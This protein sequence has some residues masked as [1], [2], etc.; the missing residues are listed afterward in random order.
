MYKGSYVAIVTPFKN[1][2]IDEAGLRK[3]L[4]F[5]IDNGSDGIVACATTG[6]S[7]SLS[8]EEYERII[9]ICLEEADSKVPVIAGAGTNSTTKTIK[10][11]QKAQKLG[12]NGLLIVTPYYN[13]PTQQG[14]YQHYKTVSNETDLPIIIYNVPGR[15]GV[16][17]LPQTVA[18]LAKDCKNIVAIK[19][20]SGNLDQVSELVNLLGDG[21]DILSG[22]DSLTLPMLS[23][24]AKGVISVIANI[25]PR[26]VSDMCHFFINGKFEEAKKLH[27]KM[28]PVVKALFIETNP[29]PVKKAME[30]MGLP[31]GNPRLPLV[32][33]SEENTAVLRKRLLE[34][35]VKIC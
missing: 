4:R 7:P 19:E 13:K 3:N 16:N 15:T 24:G 30:L 21:F 9:K 34:Y 17:I 23:I 27:I 25:F 26:D 6:E 14:L 18:R 2:N 35:G 5:L 32:P 11:A 29:I 28:F 12:A 31:A 8:D 33:M 1:D 10:T 22:D 20:A